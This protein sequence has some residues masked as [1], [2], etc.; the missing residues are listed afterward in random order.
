MSAAEESVILTS[1]EGKVRNCTLTTMLFPGKFE[2]DHMSIGGAHHA[3]HRTVE[4][5]LCALHGDR[6]VVGGS[7][8]LDTSRLSQE[9]II[10]CNDFDD[11]R[12]VG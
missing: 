7:E 10:G 5:E 2:I 8:G 12:K 6:V 11:L 3:K 9:H 1:P 4:D